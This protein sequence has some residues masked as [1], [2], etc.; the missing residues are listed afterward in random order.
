M[1]CVISVALPLLFFW[2]FGVPFHRG[3]FCNDD[4][5]RHPYRGNTVENWMLGLIATLLPFLVV[6]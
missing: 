6:S 5:I 4:S 3:F 2:V 1:L